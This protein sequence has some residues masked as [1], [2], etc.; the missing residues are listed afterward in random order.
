VK[1][2]I[3]ISSAKRDLRKMPPEVVTEFGYGLYQAQ[4]GDHPDIA[5][6]LSGFGGTSVIELVVSDKG[7]AFRAVYTIKFVDAVVVLHAFQKKSKH[8]IKT[9]KQ[10]IEL[11]RSRLKQAE[12]NYYEWKNKKEKV[13]K[14]KN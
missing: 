2:L 10:D 13:C 7:N 1:E 14:Q 3:W 6:P 4:L 5:K 11:I 12:D 9:T 8:G